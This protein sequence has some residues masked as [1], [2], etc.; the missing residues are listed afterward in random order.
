MTR[1]CKCFH[2]FLRSG[3]GAVTVD[4]VV[5]TALII[6]FA[7]P[8]GVNYVGYLTGATEVV[9]SNIAAQSSLIPASLLD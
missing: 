4:W 8:I 7:A 9:A 6:G 2:R 3:E 5:L 1:L